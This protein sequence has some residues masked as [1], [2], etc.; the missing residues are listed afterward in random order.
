MLDPF[1]EKDVIHALQKMSYMH[2]KSTNCTFIMRPQSEKAPVE[3]KL[4]PVLRILTTT[5]RGSLTSIVADV[6][7]ST[8][9]QVQ[10]CTILMTAM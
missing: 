9:H 6:A 1:H 3:L 2:S 4:T 10:I 8:Q 5:Q 7:R